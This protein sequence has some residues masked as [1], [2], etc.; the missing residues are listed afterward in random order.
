MADTNVS[1]QITRIEEAR[2]L[3]REIL[4]PVSGEWKGEFVDTEGKSTEWGP[5]GLGD[6]TEKIDELAELLSN[7]VNRGSPALTVVEGG[8]IDLPRGFYT[9]GSVQGLSDTTG[10]QEKY[11]TQSK[12]TTPSK[13]AI[14]VSP[15]TGYYAL[16][17]VIIEPIPAKY[18]DVSATTATAA[19]VLSGKKLTLV[20]GTIATGTMT[21]NGS[22][23]KLLTPR[24]QAGGTDLSYTIPK[25][26]HD[27]TGKVYIQAQTKT[28]TPTKSAQ[29]A[30]VD[31]GYVLSQVT[32][33]PIPDNFID[34]TDATAA[35]AHILTGK[36]AYVNTAKVTGSMADNGAIA[37]TLPGFNSADGSLNGSTVDR[38]F[39]YTVPVG[40]HN[41]SGTVTANADYKSVTPTKSAQ[42]IYPE[43]GHLLWK[44]DVAAIP[45]SWYDITGTTAAAGQVLAGS[46]FVNASGVLTTGTMANQGAKTATLDVTTTSYTIPAGY[47]NG[48]GKVSIATETKS[49]TPTKSA[50]SITPT[51]GKVLSSVSVAAIPAEYIT[52]TDATATAANILADKTAYVNGIK[53]TGT[54]PTQ[55]GIYMPTISEE[56]ITEGFQGGDGVHGQ[57]ITPLP[58]GYHNGSS[59]AKIDYED[60]TVTPTKS[61]QSIFPTDGYMIGHVN[62]KAIP[63]EYITTTDATAVAGDIVAGK[64]A[65]VNGSKI[66]GTIADKTNVGIQIMNATPSSITYDGS[67]TAQMNASIADG[68]YH[69]TSM[70]FAKVQA[71]S[72]TPTKSAQTIYPDTNYFLGKVTVNAIPAAYQDVSATTATAASVLS[73]YK[74]TN[75]SGTVVTGT[76]A[77]N[78]ATSKTFNPLTQTSVSIAAGYTTGGSV[79]LTTDLEERLAAI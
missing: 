50:Q 79:T 18:Q 53:V 39:K 30:A 33:A 5:W 14:T 17:S 72:V 10:D 43:E 71:K 36:T 63:A 66:T 26:Y 42:T 64:T 9:G 75:A 56:T 23:T 58:A 22:I 47:H 45:S 4:G 54:M 1:L 12:T 25:G 65:Y 59:S 34:T 13:T 27:G 57:I 7:V 61:A 67:N 19:D 28:I 77:N 44:V 6:G 52:T 40:Y 60:I 69:D 15:D 31:A 48:S 73:G 24:T 41:G 70:A 51:A 16:S 55:T 11:K 38:T 49:V 32:V 8:S 21:N 20:D 68:Y 2:D 78:G 3:I 62:I 35:A 74:F 46:K 37:A 29:I 76:M